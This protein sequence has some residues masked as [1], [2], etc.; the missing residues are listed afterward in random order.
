MN[1]DEIT[2]FN[3]MEKTVESIQTDVSEIKLALLGNPLSGDNGLT[4]RITMLSAQ[5]T[6]LESQVKILQEEKTKNTVYVKLINWLLA[7]IA[8]AFIMWIFTMLKNS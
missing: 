2:R 5:L 4:G 7:T 6:I 8:A 1:A 3:K